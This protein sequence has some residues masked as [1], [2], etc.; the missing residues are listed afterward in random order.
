M[1]SYTIKAGDT[2]QMIAQVQL[3]DASLWMSIAT[4]NNLTYPYISSTVGTGVVT[5]G[6]DILIPSTSTSTQQDQTTFGTDLYLSTDN[7][8]ITSGNGGD[9]GVG[10]D[11]DYTLAVEMDALTQDV[12]HRLMTP[13]G[14]L[15]YHPEYGSRLTTYVGAKKD[16]N[17]KTKAQLDISSTLKSDPRITDVTDISV[18][19]IPT[20]IK[21][22]YTANANGVTFKPGGVQ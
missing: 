20:G 2:L 8:N 7:F 12:T 21:L 3:G 11:G 17:W 15:P 19:D 9:F 14:T 18:V 13:V 5:P 6:D 10:L 4:L 22:D 16:E 1:N